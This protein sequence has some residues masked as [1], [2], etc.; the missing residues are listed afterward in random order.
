MRTPRSYQQR[1]RNRAETGERMANLISFDQAR[2]A[3]VV[4]VLSSFGTWSAKAVA[5]GDKV[6][7]SAEVTTQSS[8]GQSSTSGS[9]SEATPATTSEDID[10]PPSRVIRR[11]KSRENLLRAKKLRVG[12]IKPGQ[13]TL[14]VE[15]VN[16]EQKVIDNGKKIIINKTLVVNGKKVETLTIVGKTQNYKSD[17]DAKACSTIGSI[18]DQPACK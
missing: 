5:E 14:P 10:R 1:A 2:I 18:G 17:K 9:R 15:T 12:V 11:T 3:V 4:L 8:T 16:E 6:Y 7:L 13:R